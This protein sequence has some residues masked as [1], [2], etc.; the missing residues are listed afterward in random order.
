MSFALNSRRRPE[1]DRWQKNIISQPPDSRILIDAGPGTGKTDVACARVAWLVDQ[2][3]LDPH[4]IWLISFTRT[5]VHEIRNRIGNY[6]DHPHDSHGIKIATLDSH[7]WRIHTGYDEKVRLSGLRSYDENILGLTELLGSSDE[8]TD[9]LAG[10]QHL[11]IDEAQDIVGI[12]KDLMLSF[13]ARMDNAGISVFADDAQA[14][15]GFSLRDDPVYAGKSSPPLSKAISDSTDLGFIRHNLVNIYRT[16]SPN[17]IKIFS[18]TRRKVLQSEGNTESRYLQIRQEISQNANSCRDVLLI[19]REIGDENDCFILYRKKADVLFGAMMMEKRSH[20]IRMGSLPRIIQPWIAACLS[21][22]QTARVTRKEFA[23]NWNDR[24]EGSDLQELPIDEA[25]NLLMRFGGTTGGM[26]DLNL[27]RGRLGTGAPPIEVCRQEIGPSG[28]IFSTIHASKGRETDSVYLVLNSGFPG[29]KSCREVEEEMRILF[30]GSSRAKKSLTVI[31]NDLAHEAN[32]VNSSGSR[33]YTSLDRR[34]ARMLI[35]LPQ[36][37]TAMGIAGRDLYKSSAFVRQ[38]QEFLL[39]LEGA[40]THAWGCRIGDKFA[41]RILPGP[42]PSDPTAQE[43][44]PLTVLCNS[45]TIWDIVS[46]G[47]RTMR[48]KYASPPSHFGECNVYG[49]QSIILPTG[50]P[51]ADQ[52]HQ[53]W[54]DSGMMLA[55]VIV[56]Y[57]EFLFRI[58]GIEE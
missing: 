29:Q 43:G 52:L 30:V 11:I 46:V 38:S 22:M 12:R 9:Y 49:L 16:Q 45:F 37:I 47:K 33:L 23:S 14:I 5:A 54:R 40:V 57:P 42:L 19:Q 8:V 6:L 25:W 26:V 17:L 1:W 15:Y 36:D 39:N 56:G 2:A 24:V 41:Y 7:A 58:D 20:R 13:I 35:G 55:P 44:V 53:P 50:S 18:D 3:D 51:E 32:Y 4:C 34:R 31:E 21:E 48:R 27:L 10:V 28:P